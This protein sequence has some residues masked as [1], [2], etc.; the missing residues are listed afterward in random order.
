MELD[1]APIEFQTFYFS[2]VLVV[3]P[4]IPYCNV[5]FGVFCDACE[6]DFGANDGF[7]L[8]QT[9]TRASTSAAISSVAKEPLHYR[10]FEMSIVLFC[11]AVLHGSLP[12]FHFTTEF[13]GGGN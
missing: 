9:R 12:Y 7:A 4:N 11:S 5:N 10:S 2:H 3:P 13:G 1:R 6:G 8:Q